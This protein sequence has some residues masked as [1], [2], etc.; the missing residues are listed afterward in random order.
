MGQTICV[1]GRQPALGLAELE[2]L[3]GP[4]KI[5]PLGNT[6]LLEVEW[7]LIPFFRLGGSVKLAKF[8][9]HLDSIKW[10]GIETH[11]TELLLGRAKKLPAGKLKI[12]F[13]VYGFNGVTPKMIERLSFT[14]KKR[15]IN[16]AQSTRVIPS[17]SI[18]LSSAQVIHNNLTGKLG[19][20]ILLIKDGARTILAQTCAVQDIYGYAARD[21]A[22]PKRDAKIGM[23]PPKLAQIIIN[24]ADGQIEA[25]SKNQK[26]KS[27]LDPFCGT[28]VVLQE[29]LLVGY[30]VIGTDIEPRMIDY[31]KVNI[32]WLSQKYAIAEKSNSFEV[33][34][35]TSYHWTKPIDAVASETFLGQ[36]L[37]TLPPK[38]QLDKI[39]AHVNQLH[40]KFLQNLA[41]QTKPGFRLCLA[42]PAW[43]VPAGFRHLP[44]LA[45]LKGLG[46]NRLKFVHVKNDDLIYFREGQI[47]A[48]EL[49]VL[50]RT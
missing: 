12:G 22:R 25:K 24:L 49:I 34:D 38:E 32:E 9:G 21:Q 39:V 33:G 29:A 10:A 36:P 35:A 8:L 44:C 18:E 3:L 41:S 7:S 47:V 19:W 14:I 13:S 27:M 11:I 5:R 40:E 15:L 43:K 50:E 42:M 23:L 28:G 4:E 31:T 48:R 46:Y 1:L 17:N 45:N 20:E 37:S 6:A 30:S 26:A 2:S 16:N